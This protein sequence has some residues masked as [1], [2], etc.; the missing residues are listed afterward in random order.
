MNAINLQKLASAYNR[1]QRRKR[2][3]S[4]YKQLRSLIKDTA[5]T[6]AYYVQ[7]RRGSE[8]LAVAARLLYSKSEGMKVKIVLEKDY[9][10]WMTKYVEFGWRDNVPSLVMGYIV[11][12]DD[13]DDIPDILKMNQ[14]VNKDCGM[15]TSKE[16]K[17]AKA[18]LEKDVMSLVSKFEEDYDVNVTDINMDKCTS[19]NTNRALY[20]INKIVVKVEL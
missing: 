11:L 14:L 6:G 1:K 4:F 3:I 18:K 17:D 12:D 10:K 16:M 8:E 2:I 20:S 19:W 15:K 7:T 13:Y 5:K 9:A